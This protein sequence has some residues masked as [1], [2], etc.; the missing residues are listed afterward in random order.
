M[1][2]SPA[3]RL[4][5]LRASQG[6]VAAARELFESALPLPAAVLALGE[7]DMEAGD[8]SAGVDAADRVLRNL[9]EHN[10][11]ERF[12]AL[13]LRGRACARAGDEQAAAAAAAELRRDAERLGTPY[14]RARGCLLHADVLAA[15]GDNDGARRAAEDAVDL[16]GRCAA[17]Y[18]AARAR[19]TLAAALHGLGR[20]ERAAAEARAARDALARLRGP[21][22]AEDLT[23]ELSARETEI[24]RLV[25]QGL[26]DA[27]IAERLFLS[28]HTVH[29]HVANIRAKLR[30]PSRAAAVAYAGRHGLL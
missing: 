22:E 15:A 24:L 27:Q 20:E 6:D 14:M 26:A 4:G 30:S 2:A 21:R 29:R 23:E 25:A 7:L 19:L 28:P 5:R 10:L 11:L 16:F 8:P 9:G 3:V 17:P 12:P 1:A 13:E 18:D